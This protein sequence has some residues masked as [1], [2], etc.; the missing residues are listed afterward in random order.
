M[1]APVKRTTRLSSLVIEEI[2]ALRA[3]ETSIGGPPTGSCRD[4]LAVL[5]AVTFLPPVLSILPWTESM[6]CLAAVDHGTPPLSP[7]RLRL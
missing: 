5:W 6:D 3:K 7:F 4:R 1:S 2:P